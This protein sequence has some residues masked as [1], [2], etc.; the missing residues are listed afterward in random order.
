MTVKEAR[1]TMVR[2]F[3][4]DP[5]FRRGYVDNVACVLMDR[6]PGFKRNKA[7]RDEIADAIIRLVF[8]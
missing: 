2:E 1:A 4:A 5:N 7:K 3:E 6:I 8:E